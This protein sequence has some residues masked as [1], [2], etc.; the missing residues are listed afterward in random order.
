MNTPLIPTANIAN[1]VKN[2][3]LPRTQPLLPL[4]EVISN[5]IHSID[6]AVK[7]GIL[8]KNEAYINIRIIRKGTKP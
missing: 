2:T 5:A 3:K 6:E 8:T 7:T 4:F 1:K